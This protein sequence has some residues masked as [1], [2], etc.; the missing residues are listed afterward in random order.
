MKSRR[1]FIKTT[2][3]ITGGLALKQARIFG[4]KSS[5]S[6]GFALHPFIEANPDAV[7]IMRTNVDLKTNSIAKKKA[8]QDFIQSVLIPQSVSEGG[9]PLTN[10]F[11]IKP[12]L[13]CRNNYDKYPGT[14][15]EKLEQ[16]M[17]IVSDVHFV[18]GMIESIQDL[19]VAPG[20][21]YMRE[22]SCASHWS[23]AGFT[24]LASITGVDLK[25]LEGEAKDLPVSDVQ[26]ID[27]PEGIWFRRIAYL[28]P[29]NAPDSFLINVA[30]FKSHIMGC[31]TLTAKNLQGTM[32]YPYV[33]HCRELDKTLKYDTSHVNPAAKTDIVS[34]YSKHVSDGIPRWDKPGDGL[35]WSCG[36][37]QETWATR[38]IDNHLASNI[39]LHVIEGIYGRDG[40]GFAFGPHAIE[41]VTDYTY[42][43]DFM[44]NYVIFGKNAFHVD[45]IGHWLGGHEPGNVGLFHLAMERG[46]STHINPEN[47]TVYEWDAEGN[48]VKKSYTE[49]ERYEIRTNYLR[50]NY[51]GQTEEEY[52][53]CNEEFDYNNWDPTIT[54]SEP[55]KPAIFTLQQNFPNPFSSSTNIAYRIPEA[56][57]VKIEII[58]MTGKTVDILVDAFRLSG[59]HQV[60]WFTGNKPSGI[61]LCRMYYQGFVQTRSLQLVR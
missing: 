16:S 21:M 50:R 56:G 35:T 26:W 15:A 32:A 29:V 31:L 4:Y 48:A 3:L 9:I 12:N 49:F 10:K 23:L 19:G 57:K 55:N 51:D 6:D 13:T 17:G 8:G 39:G 46:A 53:L 22:R 33:Q 37:H 52:H 28:Y 20:N 42:A 43:E 14:E 7:F 2:A 61:Y 27:I 1:D 38:C 59:T 30:K 5:E 60:S 47:I 45:I 40:D 58:D 25:P 44:T 54:S 34:N 11:V 18:H 41:G 36:L 24:E